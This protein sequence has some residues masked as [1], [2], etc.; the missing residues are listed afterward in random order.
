M[1]FA[2]VYPFVFVPL[3]RLV[4]RG[5]CGLDLM[6]FVLDHCLNFTLNYILSSINYIHTL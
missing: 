1:S 4:L 5:R 3:S 6:V 2:I